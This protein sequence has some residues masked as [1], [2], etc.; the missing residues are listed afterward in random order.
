[1]LPESRIQAINAINNY[2]R[3]N[4]IQTVI[5]NGNGAIYLAPFIKCKNKVAYKHT[6]WQSV[7]GFLKKLIYFFAINF[8]YSICKKIIVVSKSVHPLSFWKKKTVVIYNGVKTNELKPT[9]KQPNK[10]LEIIFVGRIYKQKGIWELFE[11]V[12]F[13]STKYSFRIKFVGDGP[14][15]SKLK[16]KVIQNELENHITLVGFTTNIK[17]ELNQSDIFVLPS[18]YEACSLSILESMSMGLAVAVGNKG[19]AIEVIDDGENGILF[20][21]KDISVIISSLEKLIKSESLRKKI[22][23]NA[24]KT[25]E[26]KFDLRFTIEQVAVEIENL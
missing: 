16:Q 3:L 20:P 22:G 2:I 8:S 19:G 12:K 23:E 4:N 18:Y 15:L 11:A 1:M 24:R 6:G 21:P 7:N 17:N 26:Q 9:E 14:D 13:L 5:L 10:T 25:I